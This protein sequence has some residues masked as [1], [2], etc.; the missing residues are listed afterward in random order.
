[1][2]G[3]SISM[4]IAFW[5]AVR[6]I[7]DLYSKSPD[8]I[9]IT[10]HDIT[11]QGVFFLITIVVVNSSDG[12]RKF[13]RIFIFASLALFLV[14]LYEFIVG[15]FFMNLFKDF[16]SGDS[17]LLGAKLA[18]KTKNNMIRIQSLF[19]HPIVF[20]Q[21]CA[22]V[23]PLFLAL[24]FTSK[25]LK[26]RSFYIALFIACA[27]MIYATQSRSGLLAIFLSVSI[28]VLLYFWRTKEKF[29]TEIFLLGI[30]AIMIVALALSSTIMGIV[31]GS[32]ISEISSTMARATMWDKSAPYISQSWFLGYG[33]GQSI[34]LGGL[35][36]ASQEAQYSSVDD[37]ALSII[38]NFGLL[39]LF[40]FALFVGTILWSN[41]ASLVKGDRSLA[42]IYASFFSACVA[43]VFVQKAISITD[44]IALLYVISGAFCSIQAK[45]Y[46]Q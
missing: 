20:A 29:R 43:I 17:L 2:G 45:K 44:N 21:Y 13:L 32:D 25:R 26:Y 14:G 18:L 10:I 28:F 23:A 41:A 9:G 7:A 5:C 15:D 22:A 11:N 31:Y 39:G 27:F 24:L 38:L 6:I 37:S 19:G 30:I 3:I 34:F 33:D 46:L 36:F 12:L 16:L 42:G 35:S 4:A 40:A 8:A 1:V